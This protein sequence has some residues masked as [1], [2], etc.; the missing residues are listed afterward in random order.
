MTSSESTKPPEVEKAADEAEN[1]FEDSKIDGDLTNLLNQI[2][3]GNQLDDPFSPTNDNKEKEKNDMSGLPDVSKSSRHWQYCYH[4]PLPQDENSTHDCNQRNV[5]LYGVGRGRDDASRNVK[6]IHKDVTKLFSKKFSIDVSDGGK[7][8]KHN[9]GDVIFD[10]VV[11]RF[12]NLSYYDQHC[13]SYICGQTMIEMLS[14]FANS[15]N[16]NYLPLPEYVSFLFDLTGLAL[17]IQGILD[18]CLQILK[19]LPGVESQLIERGSCLTRSYT[20]SLSL[21][22]VGVLRRYHTIFLL[23]PTDVVTAFEQ[24]SRIAYRPKLPME[25]GASMMDC[26]SA[27]W[28]ILAYLYDLSQNCSILKARDKFADLKRLFSSV[29]TCIWFCK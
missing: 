16:A 28:C 27:E 18:W 26:N 12:Q 20:T 15:C 13:V 29:S 9:K 11:R 2:K 6:K 8:K 25:P 7:V 17:N 21:Y 10:Q 5:L 3:E 24:L 22:I 4:F 19:E 1:S 23:N 14:A